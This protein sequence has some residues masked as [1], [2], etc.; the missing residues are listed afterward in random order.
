MGIA[1]LLG[2]GYFLTK[3]PAAQAPAQPQTQQNNTASILAALQNALNPAIAPA[4]P[5][6]TQTNNPTLNKVNQPLIPALYQQLATLN[7]FDPLKIFDVSIQADNKTYIVRFTDGTQKTVANPAY[8][9]D[10]THTVYTFKYD[11]TEA[12]N[13]SGDNPLVNPSILDKGGF[14]DISGAYHDPATGQVVNGSFLMWC[15]KKFGNSTDILGLTG[16]IQYAAS[17]GVPVNWSVKYQGETPIV[18]PT[19]GQTGTAKPDTSHPNGSAPSGAY[20]DYNKPAPA[21]VCAP[22]ANGNMQCHAK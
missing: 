9:G 17:M 15:K 11:S 22:D 21:V 1:S 4:A 7:N 18:A 10:A 2:I 16:Y 12:W 13:S 3:K 5:A 20:A 19:P 6:A 14:N 8:Q